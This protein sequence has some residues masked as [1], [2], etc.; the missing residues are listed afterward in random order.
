VSRVAEPSP[1]ASGIQDGAPT[2]IPGASTP[3]VTVE[4][5]N[6]TAVATESSAQR[7]QSPVIT[8]VI[9][10]T[11]APITR[12]DTAAGLD[13]P[14]SSRVSPMAGAAA[15]AGLAL[16]GLA[17]TTL[18]LRRRR[19]APRPSQAE[20]DVSVRA[21]FAEAESE[22]ASSDDEL[23]AATTIAARL[24]RAL[25]I[26]IAGRNG[27]TS[28][29]LPIRGTQLVGVRHGRSSTTLLLQM[30]IA[31]RALVFGCLRDAAT[32]AFGRKSD[33]E[34]VVSRDGDVVIRLTAVADQLHVRELEDEHC[35]A[36][37]WPAPSMLLR[38][39]LLADRQL[40]AANWDAL[41]HVLVASPLSQSAEAILG[42]LLTS[43]VARRSPPQLGFVVLG[44][45]RCLPDE[46]LGMPHRLE[47]VV[48]P[49]DQEGALKLLNRVRQELEERVAT[50][51]TDG[52]DLVVVVPELVQ[53]SAEHQVALVG[54]FR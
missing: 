12:T 35:S 47:P 28:E 15:G 3:T 33:V 9:Q 26:V 48:D 44:D 1:E 32:R 20:S 38:L 50:G 49:Q 37:A 39:G 21:G 16:L 11:R 25:A 10:P 24:S 6:A 54:E 43:L 4:P 7:T 34:A 40:F 5:S 45:P 51:A 22:E 14:P 8:P 18:V 2:A 31:S 19:H 36:E 29:E 42:G 53:L 52:P 41:S 30:P 27:S 13:E 23:A 17:G 46:L